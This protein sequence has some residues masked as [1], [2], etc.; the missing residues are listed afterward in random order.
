MQQLTLT[1][2]LFA[3]EPNQGNP[4]VF[5]IL[6]EITHC[7]KKV[8]HQKPYKTRPYKYGKHARG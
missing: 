1:E 3:D 8:S 2:I 4:E 5:N 6:Y 7:T